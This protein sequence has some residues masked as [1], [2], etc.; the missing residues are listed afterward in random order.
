MDPYSEGVAA[1]TEHPSETVHGL[2]DVRGAGAA[3]NAEHLPEEL[4][5][6]EAHCQLRIRAHELVDQRKSVNADRSKVMPC[7][8]AQR[9]APFRDHLSRTGY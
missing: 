2:W 3:E 7:H 8:R 1:T 6:G 4:R 9:V 5:C